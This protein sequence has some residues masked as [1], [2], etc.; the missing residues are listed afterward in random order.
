M[1]NSGSV[2]PSYQGKSSFWNL[3][4]RSVWCWPS[5]Q[6]SAS[7]DEAAFALRP[8]T[9]VDR[10]FNILTTSARL[11]SSSA[12]AGCTEGDAA[13]GGGD[14]GGDVGGVVDWDAVAVDRKDR[15]DVD[16]RLSRAVFG[17]DAGPRLRSSYSRSV[18]TPVG[19]C[20]CAADT[21]TG[22]CPLAHGLRGEGGE[23][24]LTCAYRL[25]TVTRYK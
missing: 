19:L 9:S 8:T 24:G 25:S 15:R 23:I 1:N 20:P 16:T 17:R 10:V 11:G 18:I 7:D 3:G 2:L 22:L 12:M 5:G 14:G 4:G 13:E 21:L 6:L